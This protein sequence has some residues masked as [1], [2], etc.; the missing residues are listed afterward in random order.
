MI[1]RYCAEC[2]KRVREFTKSPPIPLGVAGL[3]VAIVPRLAG[4]MVKNDEVGRSVP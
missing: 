1:P 3:N 2:V 4:G